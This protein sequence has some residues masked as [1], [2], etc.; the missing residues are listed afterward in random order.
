MRMAIGTVLLADI[1]IRATALRAHYTEEG[2]LPVWLL[3]KF[4]DKPLRWS[5]HYLNDSFVYE[6]ILFFIHGLLA[7]L[8]I[9][10]YRTRLITILSWIFLI[11]LQNRNPFIQQSGDDL[12]RMVLF[13][14]IFLPWGNY[15]SVDSSKNPSGSIRHFSIAAFGYMVLI[16]SVYIFSA[17]LKDSPEWRSE[18]TAIYY[19]LSLDQI[20]V[21]L[22]DYL[23]QYPGLMKF[24]T[25]FVFYYLEIIAPLLIIIPYKNQTLRSIAA[26]S[27]ICLHIGIGSTLYVGLFFVIGISSSLGLLSKANMD[28]IERKFGI[29]KIYFSTAYF[30]VNQNKAIKYISSAFLLIVFLFCFIMNLSNISSFK[31]ALSDKAVYL[32]NAFKLDQ[33]WGMFSPHIYKTDG[34]YVYRGI[35]KDGSDYDI[36]NDT[37][38][39]DLRKPGHIDKMYPTDRWRKFAENYQKN[40]FN[41]MRPFYCRMRIKQWNKK[42]PEKRIEG[43]NILFME[44]ETLPDYKTKPVKQHNVC[45]CYEN[46]PIQ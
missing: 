5:F 14:G 35:R 9:A 2:V 44:E 39:L 38:P 12:L 42:H 36:Y 7:L 31:Y 6:S 46:D 25:L 15:Y 10:G 19:A 8:L 27:I 22:G 21:G 41:F 34:W 45:L 16:A 20:K 32:G 11:S 29:S 4:D 17:V 28:W 26:L 43:L 33:F 3:L 37:T 24:L 1:I 18:G 30:S 40:D 23:Y 13:W